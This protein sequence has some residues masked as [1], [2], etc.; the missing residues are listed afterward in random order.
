MMQ[1]QQPVI[2]NDNQITIGKMTFTV[3]VHFGNIPLEEILRRRVL[4]ELKKVS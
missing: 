1:S 4:S 2:Q 3:K